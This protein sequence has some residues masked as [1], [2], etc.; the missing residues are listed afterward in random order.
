MNNIVVTGATSMIGVALIEA[1]IKAD[2]VR[3]VYA[4]VRPDSRKIDRL[5]NDGRIKLIKCRSEEYE[6]LPSLISENCDVFYHFAWPRTATYQ[7]SFDDIVIKSCGIQAT[8]WAVHAAAKLRCAKFVGC[9]SQSEYG[10]MDVEKIS[11]EMPCS[12]VRA[13]GVTRLAC[14]QLAEILS[15]NLGLSCIWMRVFSVYGRNDRSNSMISSTIA[16]LQRGERC[17]FTEARQTWDYL[18]AEDAGRAFYLAGEKVHGSHIYCVGSGTARPLREYI[19]IIRDVAAPGTALM[20]GKLS[21]P[22]NPVMNLCADISSLQ[23]DTGWVPEISFEEGIRRLVE[24][25]R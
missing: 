14:G 22:L 11:P 5:P 21:Q 16:K 8:L 25:Y 19:E 1:A 2:G 23:R 24:T 7:E 9:G 10:L 15:A 13:D 3:T 18:E 12:P 4:V 6:K 17:A 20:F